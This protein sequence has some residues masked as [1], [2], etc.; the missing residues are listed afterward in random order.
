MK[1][2][3]TGGLGYIGSHVTT[4]LLE[5]DF[6]VLCLDNLENSSESVL[7]GINKITGKSPVFENIDIRDKSSLKILLDEHA[8]IKGVI[9]FAAYKAVEESHKI[10][11]DYYQNNIVGLLNLLELISLKRIPLIFSSSCTVY[12]QAKK[13]P[14]KESAPYQPP[15]SPYGYTKQV[16]EQII[17][18]TCKA[19]Q[20]FSAISL[21]YF[22]PIGA[23]PTSKIGE[24]PRGVPQNLVP[25]LTQT[26]IGKHSVLKVFG[27]NYNTPDGTCIRDYIHVM[28][29]AQAHIDSLDFLIS[30]EKSIHETF[31]VGTGYGVSVLELIKTFEKVTGEEVPFEYDEPRTGDTEAAFADVKKIEKKIGWKSKYSLEEALK[32]AWEWEKNQ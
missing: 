20:N 21:R 17:K 2:L 27:S 18:H 28:D 30:N 8:D 6:E 12:G 23:H 31:N 19:H 25:F 24:N 7:D 26:V 3:V 16:G 29:L 10:P 5:K 14:I 15:I 4:L 1:I 11:L 22:N 13:L 32:N 9:H